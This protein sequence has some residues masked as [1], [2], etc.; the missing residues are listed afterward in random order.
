[1]AETISPDVAPQ[2]ALII[3]SP[4]ISHIETE[5]DEPLDN[6][7]SAKQQRLLVEPLYSSWQAEH[8]FVADAN[9]GIFSA[10]N[11]PP[12]VPD[13]FLSLDVALAEDW[14]AKEHRSYFIWEFGKPPDVVME[15]VSNEKRQEADRKLR[16]YARIRITYYVIYDPQQLIQETP[17]RVYELQAG[18]YVLRPD[19]VLAQI[20]LGLTLWNGEFEGKETQWL[21]WCDVDGALIPTGAERA[22]QEHAR[23]EQEHARAERLAARLRE[24]GVDPDA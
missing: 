2:D 13:M 5:D 3:D 17:L 21:R 22:E 9:V 15:I 23:A 14:F 10:T 24:L 12:I 1:V 4:D 19:Y 8:S 18:Q 20:G 11:R 16:E 7:F 6:I